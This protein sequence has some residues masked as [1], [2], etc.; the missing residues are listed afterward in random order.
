MT[1]CKSPLEIIMSH[2]YGFGDLREELEKRKNRKFPYRDK[3]RKIKN[4]N[5]GSN[6]TNESLR[7]ASGMYQNCPANRP[8]WAAN[9]Y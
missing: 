1:D 7:S 9:I 4:V 5:Y 2:D 8:S 6:F 3:V